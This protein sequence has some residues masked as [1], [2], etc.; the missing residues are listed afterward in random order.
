MKISRQAKREAK[1]LF[2]A[3]HV[4]DNLSDEKVRETVKL[5]M[6]KS[7]ATTWRSSPTCIVWSNWTCNV[8]LLMCKAQ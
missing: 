8:G 6:E 3:C 4:E 5:L 2:Q 1:Q 7:P